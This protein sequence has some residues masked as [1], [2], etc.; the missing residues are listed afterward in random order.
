[1][2]AKKTGGRMVSSGPIT[3]VDLALGGQPVLTVMR[4]TDNT[5]GDAEFIYLQGCANTAIGSV[6]TYDHLGQTT[7]I[8]AD[9]SGPVAVAMAVV[10]AITK[11][12]WYCI[13]GV[14]PAQVAANSAVAG[15]TAKNPGFELVAGQV[16]DGRAAGDEIN[17]FYQRVATA[18]AAAL[19]LCQI[20]HPFVNNFTGA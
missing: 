19:A 15:T 1:M 12:G 8:V 14:V 10:D 9:A 3:R 6:V 5:D 13:K 11:Y 20:D 4:G 18:G 17:N 2:A 16:G 7:L